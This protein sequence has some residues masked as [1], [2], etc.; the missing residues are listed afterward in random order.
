[1][2]R[3]SADTRILLGIF[4]LVLA[5]LV[6]A[7]LLRPGSLLRAWAEGGITRPELGG[8]MRDVLESARPRR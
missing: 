4:V 6:V 8:F 3:R 2:P 5:L 7:D 1:M